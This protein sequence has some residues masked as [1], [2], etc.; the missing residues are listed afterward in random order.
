MSKAVIR[1]GNATCIYIDE[2]FDKDGEAE[3]VLANINTSETDY[4]KIEHVTALRDQLNVLIARNGSG[5]SDEKLSDA[6]RKAPS[7]DCKGNP[8]HEGDTIRRADGNI[9]RVGVSAKEWFVRW[10]DGETIS[11]LRYWLSEQGQAVVVK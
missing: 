8:I 4:L 3:I 1:T 10:S 6:K 2:D 9:G 11:P 7:P 5:D